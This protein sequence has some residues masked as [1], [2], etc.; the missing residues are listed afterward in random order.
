ME[1]IATDPVAVMQANNALADMGRGDGL[2]ALLMD[3]PPGTGK[4]YLAKYLAFALKAR[5]IRFQIFPNC[6]REDLILDL[7]INP[8]GSRTPGV[9]LQA[10]HASHEGKVVLLLD[11]LDK[12]TANVDSFL[13]NY[14]NDAELI[15]PQ[16]GDFKANRENLLV[17][18]T[19]NDVREASAPLLRRC[20]VTYMAW[21]SREVETRILKNDHPYLTEEAADA[22]L[23]IPAFL[24]MNPDVKKAPSTPEMIRLT[25]DILQLLATTQVDDLNLGRYYVNSVAQSEHDQAIV[26]AH[27]SPMYL[28]TRIGEAFRKIVSHFT[29]AQQTVKIEVPKAVVHEKFRVFQGRT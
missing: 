18:I 29:P 19:K 9:L 8:D 4:S 2:S 27:K 22:L 15:I 17:V 12:A 21:P 28:G 5:L 6:G 16:L 3:G 1:Y 13:L 10:L 20:R 23:D 24:R 25:R 14:L 11:E 26:L 7:A